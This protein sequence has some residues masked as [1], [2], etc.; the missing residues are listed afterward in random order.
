M[1]KNTQASGPAGSGPGAPPTTQVS[2]R[3]G[4]R[5]HAQA[6]RPAN[7]LTASLSPSLSPSATWT[8]WSAWPGH[9]ALLPPLPREARSSLPTDVIEVG[10][11]ASQRRSAARAPRGAVARPMRPEQRPE[12]PAAR[13]VRA[14]R[15]EQ[16][17]E[18]RRA[19][20]GGRYTVS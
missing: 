1:R 3:Y 6:G 13:L 4:D 2:V 16:P 20:L 10:A 5:E 12:Q 17:R 11:P 9:P 14:P 7:S 18:Q 8:V 19:P 15:P